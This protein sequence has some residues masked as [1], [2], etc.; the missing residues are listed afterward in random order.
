MGNLFCKIFSSQ[1]L[2]SSLGLL[3]L[4][5]GLGGSLL[6]HGIQKIENFSSL[7][8]SFPDPL[9]TGSLVA[10]LLAIFSEA[11]CSF[12]VIVGLWTRAALVPLICTFLT[13]CFV[14]L[15]GK[16]FGARELPFIYLIGFVTLFFTGSGKYAIGNLLCKRS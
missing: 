16:D 4:R 14:V 12:L 8:G 3:V 1:P 6:T 7:S 2:C 15:A 9:G 13:I 11:I 10:L 5:L